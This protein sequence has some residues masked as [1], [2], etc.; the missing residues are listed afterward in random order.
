VGKMM[1]GETFVQGL[2]CRES[3][4]LKLLVSGYFWYFCVGLKQDHV[5]SSLSS[6][7][8]VRV[9]RVL[10]VLGPVR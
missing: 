3:V 4:S 5:D 9:K 1:N 2:V 8:Q 10:K 6:G 7:P